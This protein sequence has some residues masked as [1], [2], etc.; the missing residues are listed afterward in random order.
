MTTPPPLARLLI[1]AAK[2]A[3][4]AVG[5][6][7]VFLVVG[8]TEGIFDP[9]PDWLLWLFSGAAV[10]SLGSSLVLSWYTDRPRRAAVEQAERSPSERLRE[11]NTMVE[12]SM[13]VTA[14]FMDRLV[15]ELESQKAA[16]EATI[17]EGEER[18]R[19]LDINKGEA[20]KMRQLLVG[21]TKATISAQRRRDWMLVGIGALISIPIGAMINLLVP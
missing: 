10:V 15:R 13:A 11:L 19:W 21:E 6:T 20:E 5:L 1:V 12:S 18:A 17:A 3:L 2:K 7:L 16:A 8:T 9:E 4:A 14:Q